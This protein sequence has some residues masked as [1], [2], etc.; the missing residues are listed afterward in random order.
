L[1]KEP[2]GLALYEVQTGKRLWVAKGPQFGLDGGDCALAP[3]A[4]FPDGNTVLV[5]S[6]KSLQVWD[7]RTGKPAREFAHGYGNSGAVTLSTTGRLLLAGLTLWDATTGQRLRQF[8]LVKDAYDSVVLSPD[9]KLALSTGSR[10]TSGPNSIHLWD[11]A[12][13]QVIRSFTFEEGWTGPVTFAPDGKT[14]VSGKRGDLVM[15]DIATG[16]VITEFNT[17]GSVAAFTADGKHLLVK[18]PKS[19]LQVWEVATAREVRN[20]K[21]DGGAHLAVFSGDSRL[22]LSAAGS[23]TSVGRQMSLKVWDVAKGEAVQTL[24]QSGG[25]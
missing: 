10:T 19:T 16:K 14:A 18:G 20:F 23:D 25:P 7:V 5:R 4:F 8:D 2:R 15:W 11:V 22:L 9:G 13:G 1:P 6:P 21:L 12:K 24:V 3:V 17:Y